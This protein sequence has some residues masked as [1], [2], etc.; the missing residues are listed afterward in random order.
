MATNF[1]Y[2]SV[3]NSLRVFLKGIPQRAV[4]PR[5]TRQHLKA[6]GLKSSNDA[7]IISVLKFI[8][9]VGANGNPT[10]EYKQFRDRTKGPVVLANEIREGY[11]ALYDTY[12]D[13]YAQSDDVLRNFFTAN[14]SV[15]PRAVQYIV[16]TFKVLC[17]FA[18]FS[19]P[20]EAVAAA[21]DGSPSVSAMA[22][23]GLRVSGPQI[24]VNLEI[25]LPDAKDPETYEAIFDAMAR[26][27]LKKIT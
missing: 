6:I 4:P 20:S 1:A 25:H 27:L 8:N 7:T 13:A 24:H 16:A 10:E 9:L 12:E 26:K 15:G 21:G 19:K 23:D 2:T 11:K 18:D 22:K 14:T 5:I 17:E 3:P